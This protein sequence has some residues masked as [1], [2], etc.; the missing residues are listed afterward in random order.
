MLAYTVRRLLLTI[1]VMLLVATAVFLLLHLTPGDPVG[2]MLGTDASEAQRMAVRHELGL[3]RP[4]PVQYVEWLSRAV[5]GDL[6][7]S[8]FLDQ[9]V[10]RALL[11]RVQ[12][13]LLLTVMS[14]LVAICIG[15]PTG[16]M[17]A[18]R[19]GSWVDLSVMGVAM[20]GISMPTFW[21][22]LNLILLFAVK[23]RWL[24]V[25]GY[26]P[27]SSGLWNSLRYLILPSLTLGAAQG[28]L[29]A[30]MTRSMMLDVLNQDYIRTARA[31]GLVERSVVVRH[32][33][34]NAFIPLL[35]VIGLTFAVLI[36]GAV[37]T[38]Q[39]FNIPGVGRLLILAIGR[40]D[41]PLVQGAVLIIAALY[42]LINLA[43]DLLYA[44]VDPRIRHA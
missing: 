1:P 44:V 40:R 36:G 20:L 2:V 35:T 22:G 12:P 21:L 5:R 23:L 18:R 28:A 33:L 41:F 27:L 17:A 37:V 7:R 15:L 30:R 42:V 29:L 10:T 25:A 19:R 4:L 9:P 8:L 6:G 32:A 43:V 26:E 3:D 13:T 16:V 34:R 24:P 11:D 39:I 38:E 14:S 31:K